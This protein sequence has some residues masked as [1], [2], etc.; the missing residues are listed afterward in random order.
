MIH[1]LE[2]GGGDG[3]Q[4]T[5][6]YYAPHYYRDI[7]VQLIPALVKKRPSAANT[8]PEPC[9]LGWEPDERPSQARRSGSPDATG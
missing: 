1:F 5:P 9:A 2:D 3:F 6:S 4:I 8:G 7:I